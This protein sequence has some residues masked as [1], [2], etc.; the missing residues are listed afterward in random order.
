LQI[1]GE[2]EI[3]VVMGADQREKQ[4]GCVVNSELPEIGLAHTLPRRTELHVVYHENT[5]FA[6]KMSKSII[7]LTIS[8]IEIILRIE[9][10][11]FANGGGSNAQSEISNPDGADV[12]HSAVSE[13]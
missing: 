5:G 9:I 7:C 8:N 3:V 10:S 13:K 2:T 12:L 6:M 1:N 11:I 4:D